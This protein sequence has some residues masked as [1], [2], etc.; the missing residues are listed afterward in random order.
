[1]ALSSSIDAEKE[2]SPI[3]KCGGAEEEAGAPRQARLSTSAWLWS[4]ET[5]YRNQ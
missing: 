2:K 4:T 1:M 5:L 3:G